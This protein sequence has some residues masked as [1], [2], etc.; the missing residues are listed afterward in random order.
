M[1]AF[2]RPRPLDRSSQ[3]GDLA[4]SVRW[5]VQRALLPAIVVLA[6]ESGYLL[7]T[8]SP[9]A[10][11]FALIALGTL[12][13]LGLWRPRGIGLPLVPLLAVQNLVVYGLP[14]VIGH[15]VL[16]QYPRNYITQAGLE[17]LIF[18]G[19]L[20]IAW[21][22]GMGLFHP[23]PSTSY[24]LQE[25]QARGV[26]QAFRRIGFSLIIAGSS[27]Y[28]L[29]DSLQLTNIVFGIL[30]EGSYSL[31]TTLISAAG[32]CG[33]FLVAMFVGSGDVSAGGRLLFWGLLIG[34]CF[35]SASGFLL[36]ATT[37]LVS[38]VLIG[39][40]WSSGRMPWRYLIVVVSVLS[41]LNLGKFTMREQYWT[42]EGD[43][44]QI[45]LGQMPH[46]YA[47]W[48]QASYAAL[49]PPA[50]GAA[51]RD[52]R[53]K[54]AKSQSLLERV[55]N[56]QNLLFVIDA[57]GCRAHRPAAGRHVHLDS[58][59]ADAAHPLAGQAAHARGPDPAQCAF[60]TAGARLHVSNLHRVGPPGGGLR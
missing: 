51:A 9:G 55:N 41:F 14:I 38:S 52:D 1:T 46:Y 36:S 40:F 60:R 8:G 50:Q 34:D 45:T 53:D 47:E 48:I 2:H 26:R 49:A 17:V 20:A 42:P 5:L 7:Y 30:P 21:R 29:L 28:L 58:P 24:A 12:V 15:E 13:A 33:F 10:A 39:L 57:V 37:A 16:T 31:V 54:K 19:S 32:A 4:E 18:S 27:L 25:L 3:I 43:Q 44:P 56:L 6:A 22:L 23:A 11:A 59:A 35:I